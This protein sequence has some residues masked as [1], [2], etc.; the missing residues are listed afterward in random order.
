MI[1]CDPRCCVCSVNPLNT[2][3]VYCSAL[4]F[5]CSPEQHTHTHTLNGEQFV[6]LL[7]H[8]L[9]SVSPQSKYEMEVMLKVIR[10][11]PAFL[12]ACILS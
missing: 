2:V 5:I 9:L 1:K 10:I 3:V 7:C 4:R 8:F 6:R 11:D 12:P